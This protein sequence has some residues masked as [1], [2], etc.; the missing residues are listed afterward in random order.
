MPIALL[1]RPDPDHLE[2]GHDG[3]TFRIA[4]RRRPTAR[5]LTLRVSAATG[6]VVI[7]LPQRTAISTAQRFA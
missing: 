1:R 2:I 4:V 3:E 7:T 5:R 6:E